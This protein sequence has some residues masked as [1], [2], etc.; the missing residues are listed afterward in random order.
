MYFGWVYFVWRARAAV[1][2]WSASAG[3]FR[4]PSPFPAAAGRA[5][6]PGGFVRSLAAPERSP[7]TEAELSDAEKAWASLCQALLITNEFRYVD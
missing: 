1:P 6:R 3:W 7:K 4:A 5:P 2:V